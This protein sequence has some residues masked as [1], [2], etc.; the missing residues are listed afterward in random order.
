MS[1]RPTSS[2]LAPWAG[3]FLGAAGWFAHHQIASS[4]I[5]WDCE[6]GTP[7]LTVGL[8][9]LFGLVAAAGGLVSWRVHIRLRTAREAGPHS[10][11][12]AGAIGAGAAAIFLLAIGFQALTGVI[13]PAC[14][15]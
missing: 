7:L 4:V 10:R 12:V 15:R 9:V 11:S 1:G 2:A 6:L 14:H 3:L 13:L 5:D 8:G